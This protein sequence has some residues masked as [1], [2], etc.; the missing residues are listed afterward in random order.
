MKIT[1]HIGLPKSAT[2]TLQDTVFPKYEG[3]AFHGKSRNK[4]LNQLLRDSLLL[5]WE[6]FVDGQN[7]ENHLHAWIDGALSCEQTKFLI[8]DEGLMQWKSPRPRDAAHWVT[9]R[10]PK[11]DIPRQ[12]SHPIV[13]FLQ[14]IL[15]RLPDEVKVQAILTLRNQ[16]DFLGSLHAQTQDSIYAQTGRGN[17]DFVKRALTTHDSSLEFY[18]IVKDLQTTLGEH[19]FLC[20]F[21]EDGL[22]HNSKE[23]AKFIGVENYGEQFEPEVKLNNHR[24]ADGSWETARLWP[25]PVRILYY[26]LLKTG[27]G[28]KLAR[29][30]RKTIPWT[31]NLIPTTTK[32]VTISEEQKRQIK[33]HFKSDVDKLSEIMG[34]DLHELGY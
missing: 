8:S 23:I 6:T 7:F 34:R 13:E 11:V 27:F 30:I 17:Q 12:G 20:L 4:N 10:N 5:A 14:E 26:E 29:T 18:E 2:T 33:S 25:R 3:I 16:S 1:L 32:T 24:V 19:N 21:Y 28:Q 9:L 31:W 22:S 15:G